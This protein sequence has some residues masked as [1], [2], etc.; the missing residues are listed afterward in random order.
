MT[1]PSVDLATRGS[2]NMSNPK[3]TTRPR[4]RGQIVVILVG[5]IIA[6]FA[7]VGLI[8]D[9]GNA[10]ANQRN[11]QNGSDSAADAGATMLAQNFS[12]DGYSPVK[13]DSDV[14]AAVSGTITANGLSGYQ[15][16]YTDVTGQ[17][18]NMGGN[19]VSVTTSAVA[20]GSGV[21]P[22]CLDTSRCVAGYASGVRVLGHKTI[23]TF[24]ARVIGLTTIGVAADA[25]AVSGYLTSIC[26]AGAGCGI[27]PV[28]FPVTQVTCDGNNDPL[29]TVDPYEVGVRYV[30]PL[31]KNGPGN[32]G[33]LDWSPTAG[34]TSELEAAVRDPSN[35]AIRLPSWQYITG[36]GN[37]N[38]SGVDDA[39]N[40][41][42]SGKFGL[43]PQFDSTCDVQ[44]NGD[45]KGDCP[46]P[47]VGGNGSNQWYHITSVSAIWIEAAYIN[48]SNPICDTGNGA[49]SCI[50]GTFENFMTT[51]TVA[52]G[53]PGSPTAIIG[54]QL[55]R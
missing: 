24:V 21:I 7:M 14:V 29:Q 5:G 49:T 23:G 52:A 35:P 11:T 6:M 16:Y 36:T 8:V 31:C 22:P 39:L 53:G 34:G 20:V 37:I 13:N 15:A 47:N 46:P 9:G 27:L 26:D 42:C 40:D 51:G 30:I 32:V 50:I 28:T 12:A 19:P 55:I 2:H 33:W 48:G 43:M 10:F 44:P 45:N 54:V 38:S 18:L 1:K 17:M 4:E 25:T 41:C 3:D